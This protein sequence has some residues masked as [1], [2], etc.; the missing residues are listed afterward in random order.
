[1]ISRIRGLTFVIALLWQ[2]A[3]SHPLSAQVPAIGDGSPVAWP[4]YAEAAQR[5]QI[6][7]ENLPIGGQARRVEMRRID[8][9]TRDARIVVVSENGTRESA[10]PDV[11]IFSGRLADDAT[12]TAFLSVSPFGTYGFIAAGSDT[13]VISTGAFGSAQAVQLASLQSLPVGNEPY[14]CFTDESYVIGPPSPPGEANR[15]IPP[16]RTAVLAI[17]TDAEYTANL[18]GGNVG[19]ASAYVA[20]LFGAVSAIYTRDLNVR[21][22]IGYVRLWETAADP[23]TGADTGAQLDEFRNYWNANMGGV[24]RHLAHFL[25]GRGLGG[26]IAWL[27]VVC[28]P[29]YGYAVSAINGYF[30]SP[31]VMNHGANWDLMVTAHETGHNFGAP[32]THDMTPPVDN[33]A[34]GDCSVTPNGTIMS[35]CHLCPNGLADVRMEFHPRSINETI[36]PFLASTCS[37]EG[38]PADGTSLWFDGGNDYLSVPALGNS[39]PTNEVTVEFWQ[40]ADDAWQRSTFGLNPD[41]VNN[42]F[43]AH[44]PWS[45]GR[46]HWDLGNIG[47]GGRLI[48]QPPVSIV[49][50]WQHF[51]FVASQ[52]GNY[53]R[54]FRNG[55][56][57][58]EKVGMRP[59]L[60]GNFEFRMGSLGGGNFFRGKLDEMRIWN[61]ARTPAEI[62]AN[63]NQVLDPDQN[64]ALRFYWRFEEGTGSTA[65][66]LVA[67][68][69]ATRNGTDWAT[70]DDC[71]NDKGKCCFFDGTCQTTTQSACGAFGGSFQGLGTSCESDPCGA[72]GACCLPLEAGLCAVMF[73]N[74]CVAAGGSFSGE[75]ST[76]DGVGPLDGFALEFDGTNDRVTL[77][78]P[79]SMNFAGAISIEAWVRPDTREGVRSILTH[80]AV[81]VPPRET[82]LRMNGGSYEVFSNN[83]STHAASSLIPA[84]DIGRWVHLAGVYEGGV[85]KLYRNG[86]LVAS[87]ADATG[88]VTAP[89]GWAIGSRPTN[90]DRMFDGRI[91]EVRLWN[92]ARGAAEIAADFTHALVGNEAGLVG[93]WRLD[94]GAG[95]TATDSSPLGNHG[96]LVNGPVWRPTAG[97][98]TPCVGD[99]DGDGEVGLPDLTQLLSHF[100]DTNATPADGDLN[101]DQSVDLTDLTLMLSAFGVPC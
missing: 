17:E 49:G 76:C 23:W 85:W 4:T 72:P 88:A 30:P 35:Y 3:G 8:P 7:I 27:S 15:G 36:L 70:L 58:A 99:L 87:N 46:V 2:F 13:H 20:T 42:R 14:R 89:S 65:T 39:L 19:A 101:A 75:G 11:A 63:Y 26:G 50:S 71:V 84:S 100:G 52:S 33:C 57:E 24:Y 82:G 83:G 18:F 97:C 60:G 92:R 64:P 38:A 74:D 61:V 68:R 6:V 93:Y 44:V 5:D 40:Y 80:G 10:R 45:D 95:S 90:S 51:A 67:G 59:F 69:I 53:M 66:D 77:G 48:Y 31:I 34:N 16:C 96:T 12:S 56:Q 21:L 73:E 86:V 41:S 78:N 62:A 1:M 22:Q 25:S 29:S 37:L 81:T 79:A 9:F 43:Q 94:D 28:N 47:T 55:V 98:T 91:D 54:I 32:H